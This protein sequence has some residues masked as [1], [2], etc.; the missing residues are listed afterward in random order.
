MKL[1]THLAFLLLMSL[2]LMLLLFATQD[3][4]SVE[5]WELYAKYLICAKQN[6][7]IWACCVPKQLIFGKL[8]T[9][10]FDM[11]LFLNLPTNGFDVIWICT[12]RTTKT[13]LF[14]SDWASELNGRKE[15]IKNKFYWTI[16]NIQVHTDKHSHAS[17]HKVA[18]YTIMS[19]TYCWDVQNQKLIDCWG[20]KPHR[21]RHY[22]PDSQYST[23]SNMQ[24]GSLAIGQRPYSWNMDW[25]ND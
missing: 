24:I 21:H 3:T 23:K 11:V 7:I 10:V 18:Q 4:I 14:C 20:K 13:N 8:M 9:N 16:V 6:E 25:S 17:A 5:T 22:C 2:V 12:N 19:Q 15:K 1:T